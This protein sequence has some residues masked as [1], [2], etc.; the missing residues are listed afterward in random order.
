MTSASPLGMTIRSSQSSTPG[1]E[2]TPPGSLQ[3]PGQEI[4]FRSGFKLKYL[5]DEWFVDRQ[6]DPLRR[7][8]CGTDV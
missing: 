6:T 4:Y 2:R 1:S 7:K 8:L 5:M 3:N